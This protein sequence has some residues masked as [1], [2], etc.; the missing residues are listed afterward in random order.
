MI[1]IGLD[2]GQR[3]DFSA[4]AV[5][6][7]Q[8]PR[9]IVR[10]LE[11]LRLGTPYTAV[12]DRIRDLLR[13]PRL[14]GSRRLVVDATGVGMPVVDMLRSARIGCDIMPVVL[15]GA[16]KESCHGGLW[17]VPKLDLMAGLQS[18]LE[19]RELR[20]ARRLRESPAFVREM[21]DVRLS[22]GRH[23]RVGADGP[24][25]HDD[26]VIAVALAGWAARKPAMGLKSTGP[27]V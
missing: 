16:D 11:R 27:L 26:L 18:A 7:R 25:Q 10:H 9:L 22:Q 23:Q 15:T 6:Q 12:V 21:L 14:I 13:S 5:V 8:T 20:V 2:L 4:L 19:R 3:Q 1:Y 24:G 17:H